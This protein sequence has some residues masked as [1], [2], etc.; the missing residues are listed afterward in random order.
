[1]TKPTILV[2]GASRGLGAAVA[3]IAA[4]MDANVVLTARSEGDLKAVANQIESRG[5]RA[6]PVAGDVSQFGDCERMVDAAI[7]G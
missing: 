3:R 2:T 1:M 7:I 5:G 6:L 4:Q